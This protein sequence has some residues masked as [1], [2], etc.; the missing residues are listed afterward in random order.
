MGIVRPALLT[1]PTAQCVVRQTRSLSVAPCRQYRS[2]VKPRYRER[3]TFIGGHGV[4]VWTCDKP[5]R[6]SSA[7]PFPP[8]VL[9]RSRKELWHT[10]SFR[11]NTVLLFLGIEHLFCFKI[12]FNS[13]PKH[14]GGDL[15]SIRY[16][17]FTE[18]LRAGCTLQ[19]FDI[20][21]LAVLLCRNVYMC[22]EG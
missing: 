7:F 5:Q 18:K 19:S 13:R 6:F 20:S 9:W 12:S 21:R 22:S 10:H 4:N 17:R 15:Y 1:Q 11:L 8:L 2:S 16:F 3:Q 14:T